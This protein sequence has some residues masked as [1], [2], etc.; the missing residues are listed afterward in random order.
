MLVAQWVLVVWLA[1]RLLCT[2]L[3]QGRE[4]KVTFDGWD[5]VS[6][7]AFAVLVWF[8]GGFALVLGVP[9]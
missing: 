9:G 6:L 3:V 8:A 5:V 1:V 7:V 2:L 4:F